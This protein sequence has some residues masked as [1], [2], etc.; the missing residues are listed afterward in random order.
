LI[1]VSIE[2][3][4]EIHKKQE[5]WGAVLAIL[6]RMNSRNDDE[7]R[8]AARHDQKKKWELGN[9]NFQINA[10]KRKISCQKNMQ[11]RIE[12]YGLSFL[13][14]KDTIENSRKAGKVAAAKKAGFLNTNSDLHGSKYV[15]NTFWWTNTQTGERIRS[16][17]SPGETWKRGMKK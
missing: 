14:I 10:E 8:N 6:A 2:E 5:D 9:H 1:C 4:L 15:K 17:K 3:H 11:E 16:S 12:K 7:I 13:G